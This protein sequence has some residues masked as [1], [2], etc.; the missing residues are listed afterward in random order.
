MAWFRRT[1]EG[2][3]T[4]SENKLEVPEGVWWKC[5]SC[6]KTILS[7][8]MKQ[9][10]YVCTNCNYHARIN[11]HEYFEILFDEGGIKLH[12][13]NLK[14]KDFLHFTDL[15]SYK[16]RLEDAEKKVNVS[17]AITV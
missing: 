13:E 3:T 5:P 15:K 11:S 6:K 9:N 10:K 12:F 1:K 14:P 2:I 7:D 4:S 17:E 16:T 8:E